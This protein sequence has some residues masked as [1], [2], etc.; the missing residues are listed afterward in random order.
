MISMYRL[1]TFY[2]DVEVPLPKCMYNLPSYYQKNVNPVVSRAIVFL[3]SLKKE[4]LLLVGVTS[5]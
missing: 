2:D 3:F 5:S 1:P 4:Q